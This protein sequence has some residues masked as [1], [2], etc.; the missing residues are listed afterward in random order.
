MSKFGNLRSMED[1]G[2]YLRDPGAFAESFYVLPDAVSL[3]SVTVRTSLARDFPSVRK[4]L[5]VCGN[6][7]SLYHFILTL[8][9]RYDH[10]GTRG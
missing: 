7:H 6:V 3:K 8:R 9:T 2:E 1:E 4:H 5:I 10:T